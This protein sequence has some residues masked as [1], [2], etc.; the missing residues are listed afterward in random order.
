MH[1]FL[2]E[3]P[4]F[5]LFLSRSGCQ[6]RDVGFFM[7]MG[8][9]RGVFMHLHHLVLLAPMTERYSC[10]PDLKVAPNLGWSSLGAVVFLRDVRLI[11]YW[12]QRGAF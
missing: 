10:V 5:K 7:H 2:T 8:A 6:N 11:L 4:R 1:V 9:E 12:V 3:S